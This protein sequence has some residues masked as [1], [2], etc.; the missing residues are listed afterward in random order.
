VYGERRAGQLNTF[1]HAPTTFAS[2]GSPW[3]KQQLAYVLAQ[4]IRRRHDRQRPAGKNNVV[5]PGRSADAC[6][7]CWAA[8]LR[9]ERAPCF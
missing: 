5:R 9:H 3:R 7:P 2:T 8:R 4:A 1:V 6:R